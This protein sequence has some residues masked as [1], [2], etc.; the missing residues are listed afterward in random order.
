M[1]YRRPVKTYVLE[2]EDPE[3]HGLIVRARKASVK[4]LMEIMDLADAVR[5]KPTK[6]EINE[7]FGVFADQIKSW[8]L[9]D[10]DGVPVPATLAGLIS[11]DFEFVMPVI[12]AWID[13]I[14]GVP[15]PLAQNSGDGAPSPPEAPVALSIPMEAWSASPGS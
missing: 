8:N 4:Q 10:E 5:E 11:Q 2:F 9:E 13:A 1:G 6:E 14:Q 3:M 7:L 15:A 12:Y